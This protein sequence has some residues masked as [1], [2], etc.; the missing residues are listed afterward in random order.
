EAVQGNEPVRWSE[1]LHMILTIA[2]WKRPAEEWNTLAQIAQRENP[3]R[4]EEVRDMVRTAAEADMERGEIRGAKATLRRQQKVRFGELPEPLLQ[5]IEALDD[6]ERLN[7]ALDQVV[8]VKS[9]DE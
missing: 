7:A 9:L 1:L 5:Q 8:Q 2:H 3:A 6:L 4:I